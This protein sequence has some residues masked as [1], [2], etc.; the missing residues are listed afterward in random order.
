[1]S[2]NSGT[3][4]HPKT[5]ITIDIEW[6]NTQVNLVKKLLKVDTFEKSLEVYLRH[7][8]VWSPVGGAIKQFQVTANEEE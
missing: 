3:R 4:N 2:K 5:T 6:N 8:L 1:M 7:A